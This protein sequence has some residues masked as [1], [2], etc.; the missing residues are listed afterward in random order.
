MFNE[1]NLQLME[2]KE[3]K[4][5]VACRL[6]SLTK[7]MKE[8]IVESDDY[9]ASAIEND[10]HWV[11]EWKY[12]NRR[13]IV[14]YN[15]KRATKD[16][17]DRQRLIERLMKRC[18]DG[19]IKVKDL[20][21]NYGTKKYLTVNND[22]ALINE[23]K[24]EEDAQWDGLHGV[25]T[26]VANDSAVEILSRY[27][28]LWEIE[29]AFRMSKHD[30]KMRPIYHWTPE[31]IRAHIAICFIAFTLAKQSIYRMKHQ[32]MPMSFEQIR[33]ELLHVQASLVVDI[34]TSKKYIIPSHTTI[35][36]KNIYQVFGLKR[37]EVPYAIDT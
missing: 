16:A 13:L 28:G 29:E 3:V 17:A 1:D 31:R 33:N 15:A 2:D 18:K 35:N 24:I 4:Y 6:K 19:K 20:I 5:I 37:S 26:N 23:S 22:E 9:K 14:S 8:E 12:H 34:E 36:Q 10:L 25:I 11:K 30:L 7:N 27:R 32:K 21:P